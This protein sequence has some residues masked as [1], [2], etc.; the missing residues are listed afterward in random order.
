MIGSRMAGSAFANASLI[1]HR[2]GD[3]ERHLGRVDL[4]VRP[5]EERDLDVD[6]REAG[7]DARVQRLA[8][9]RVD[10]LD[11]LAR[12]G[13]ADDLVDELVA[14]ALLGRLELDDRVAVLALAAGLADEAAV[15]LGRAADG[16][17]IGDLRLAD[18]RGDLELADHPVDEDVEV[19]LAH[20]GDERLRRLRVGVDAEGRVLL[21][22][23]LQRERELV[24]VGLGLRLDLDLDDRLGEGHRLEDDLVIGVGQR[25]AGEGVL[26]ADGRRDVARVDLVDLLAVV[27][28][29]LE[30]AADPL[31]LALGRVHDV[32]AG[33]ERARVD[34]EERE[35]ADERVGRDLEG[36]RAERLAVVRGAD[37]LGAGPRVEADHRRDVERRRQE[38]DDRVEHL[39][40]ALVLQRRAG[41]DRDD[42]GRQRAEAEAALDLG[43]R[44]LLALEV[45]VGE[46]VVHLGDGLDHR[47][48][49]LLGLGLE[50]GR[51]LDH[52]DLVAQ[53]VAVVDGLHLDQVDDAL[54]L[55]LAADRDLD[56]HGVG[57]E[58]VLDRFD[59]A[60]EVGAGAVELVDEA[61]ARHA[62]AV[63]LAPDRL[64]LRLDAGDAIEDDHRAVEHAQA[65]LDLD[66]E[67]HVPGRIDDV[68]TMVAPER[69]RGRGRDGDA[70]LLLLG[71]PVHRGRAL[72]DLADLVDLLRVEEDPL[73]DGGLAGVDM[74]DDSD[75][76]RLVRAEPVVPRCS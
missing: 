23:A 64:G 70:P 27:R 32:R 51:D 35:L 45:L 33:L 71:H 46:L 18:V 26:E 21:G 14:G 54:E 53:V 56:R 40:D 15:A 5:V 75:V 48:A 17:A 55:V 63:G 36:Q 4:V 65:P 44:E 28:V 58:A 19:E 13:P 20:P 68:D 3:L 59:A 8:D 61:E 11:V 50:L 37:D 67:V 39:L 34:P 16:L 1:G 31:L 7:V 38:V 73:G 22:Q 24:L 2:A 41:Q 9:A 72:M 30:D 60:P 42:P 29:H 66:R 57:A 25:V 10:R 69:G 49:M 43:D 47:V 12:D 76:P 6:D 74:R 62:V 52:V